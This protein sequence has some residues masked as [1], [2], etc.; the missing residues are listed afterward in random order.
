MPAIAAVRAVKA[1]E[2]RIG[3]IVILILCFAADTVTG[4]RERRHCRR[5]TCG[6]VDPVPENRIRELV[7]GK[8]GGQGTVRIEA[9]NGGGNSENTFP[10]VVERMGDFPIAV[11]LVAE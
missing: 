9:E 4:I 10:D 5:E 3:T 1:A 8:R 7:D 2:M 6:A 11:Q